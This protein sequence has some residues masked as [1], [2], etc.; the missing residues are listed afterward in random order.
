MILDKFKNAKFRSRY[1]FNFLDILGWAY[2]VLFL[3]YVC[4]EIYI[5]YYLGKTDHVFG[6]GIYFLLIVL[7]SIF[8]LLI[9]FIFLAIENFINLKKIDNK[10]LKNKVFYC[11]QIIGFI[12]AFIPLLTFILLIIFAKF[13]Q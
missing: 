9:F 1:S 7:L 8:I 2:F 13:Q 3:I 12:L 5:A 6:V 10:I 4:P 11:F